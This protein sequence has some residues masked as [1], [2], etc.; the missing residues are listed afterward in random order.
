MISRRAFTKVLL[1]LT[2][3][4]SVISLDGCS[5]VDDILNWAPIGLAAFNGVI[6]LLESYGMIFLTNPALMAAITAVRTA[7]ADLIQDA[8][9]YKS[10]TPPPVG[11]LAEIEAMLSLIA[12]NIKTMFSEITANY[13]P[14]VNLVIGLVQLILGVIAGFQNQL[15]V[16]GNTG[17]MTLSDS[18]RFKVVDQTFSYVPIKNPSL[19]KFRHDWN[20]I[21]ASQGH[22]EIGIK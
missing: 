2:V 1:L 4:A 9:L 11:A 15:G 20:K 22:P 18:F 8:N 17:T 16:S 12:Q 6:T 3:G 5:T 13:S 7:F 21:C 14:V 19:K 10:I